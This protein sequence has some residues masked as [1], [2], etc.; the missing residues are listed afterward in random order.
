MGDQS[1]DEEQQAAEGC[2]PPHWG[3]RPL[4]HARARG[5]VPSRSAAFVRRALEQALEPFLAQDLPH[6]G[7][8]ERGGAALQGGGDLRDR[9]TGAAQPQHLVAGGLLG[10]SALRSGMALD[11]E[12]AVPGAEV[13]NHGGNRARCHAEAG[14][15]LRSAPSSRRL[16]LRPSAVACYEGAGD[17]L[18]RIAGG[19]PSYLLT[20]A[21]TSHQTDHDMTTDRRDSR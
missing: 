1:G 16:A 4:Q 3:R 17:G 12:L 14:G 13:S 15:H 7:A 8:V 6:A 5:V 10:R 19:R 9:V 11:E 21:H 2:V 18:A 20:R